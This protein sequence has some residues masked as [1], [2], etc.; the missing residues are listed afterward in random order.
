MAARYP[1]ALQLYSVREQAKDDFVGVL[2]QVAGMGYLGVEPAGL[3]GMTPQE[4]KKV[5]DDLGLAVPS[6]GGKFVDEDDTKRIIETA[7]VLGAEHCTTGLSRKQAATE[8]QVIEEA[9]RLQKAAVRLKA[10]GLTLT[11]HNHEFEFDTAFNGKTVHEILM[12]RAPDLNSELDT[13]WTRVGGKNPAEVIKGLAPRIPLLHIKDGPCERE[14]AQTA[15]GAGKMD[16]PPIIEAADPNTLKWLVVELDRCD[17]DM[18]EAV[19]QSVKFLAE[20][21]LGRA[22]SS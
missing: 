3:F 15:V 1:I 16:W 2:K 14:P 21:G 11:L 8:E 12:G 17:T 22:R 5:L 10:E 4:V 20:Q 19:E 9:D 18:M 13:Y 7:K 6:S